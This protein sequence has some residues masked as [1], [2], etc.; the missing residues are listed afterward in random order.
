MTYPLVSRRQVVE[1]LGSDAAFVRRCVR[2][3]HER[4]VAKTGGFMASHLRRAARLVALLNEFTDA[5]LLEEACWMTA[6]ARTLA[7]I[8]REEQLATN[9]GL[10]SQAAVFGVGPAARP[11]APALAAAE[12]ATAE[13]PPPARRRPGR[14]RKNPTDQPTQGRRR[15]RGP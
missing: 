14:P 2:L 6:Y 12:E 1:Q 9:P 13:P 3:L 7:R 4:T 10:A 5:A 11:R 8:F 15:R